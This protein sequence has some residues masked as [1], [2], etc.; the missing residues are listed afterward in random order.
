MTKGGAMMND[1]AAM[2]KS[3][4]AGEAMA[5]DDAAMMA[6][7]E[8][9]T[10]DG[11]MAKPDAMEKAESTQHDEA[12][13]K[14]DAMQSEDAMKKDDSAMTTEPE[15]MAKADAMVKP[16]DRYVAYSPAALA[17]ATERGRAVLFFKADWCPT[18]KAA[19]AEYRANLEKIPSDVTVLVANYDK[20]SELK[21]KYNV[22]YQHTFIQV[23]GEGMAITRWN[24][25]GLVELVS[26]VR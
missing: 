6:K 22:T 26:N 17:Q 15:A 9:M 11:A 3:E 8:A 20:E 10:K 1:E 21:R 2:E 23:D 18:C 24:G 12:M 16:T 25:G 14:D 5:E 19:E 13:A 7:P 4:A